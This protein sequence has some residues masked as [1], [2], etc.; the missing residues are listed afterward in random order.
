MVQDGT[1]RMDGEAR[2]EADHRAQRRSQELNEIAHDVGARL[3]NV[4]AHL[5]DEEFR[6]LVLDIA[7]N[8]QRHQGRDP[9]RP[10]GDDAT[11]RAR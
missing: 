11:G 1:G 3:K 9:T 8:K 10:R 6:Q 4:C 7:R 2:E 5:P